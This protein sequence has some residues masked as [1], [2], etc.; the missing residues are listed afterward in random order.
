MLFANVCAQGASAS[1]KEFVGEVTLLGGFWVLIGG[2]VS[3]EGTGAAGLPIHVCRIRA[4]QVCLSQD[5]PSGGRW[6]HSL[7]GLLE[8]HWF[9]M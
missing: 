8:V 7:R 1:V 3:L 9:S 2:L 6:G 4:T 5:T